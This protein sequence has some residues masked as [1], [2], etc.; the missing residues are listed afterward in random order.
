MPP[1]DAPVATAHAINHRTHFR[2]PHP[3]LHVTHQVP[4]G[5]TVCT[6]CPLGPSR[7]QLMSAHLPSIGIVRQVLKITL[8]DLSAGPGYLHRINAY[9]YDALADSHERLRPGEEISISGPGKALVAREQPAGAGDHPFCLI[10]RDDPDEEGV[11]FGRGGGGAGEGNQG[12]RV[13][14]G[15]T[16]KRVTERQGPGSLA[17][18]GLPGGQRGTASSR[19]RGGG[20]NRGRARGASTGGSER[21]RGVLSG[22]G[23]SRRSTM[24]LMSRRGS[25]PARVGWGWGKGVVPVGSIGAGRDE[26]P[27][28]SRAPGGLSSVLAWA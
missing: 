10:L 23:A 13:G 24:A 12:F 11:V 26:M 28:P 16:V 7:H 22:I 14:A 20:A 5:R 21:P 4:E 18:D 27:S 17:E 15:I 25:S 6:P 9:F 1:P 19:G 8:R 3:L 2:A